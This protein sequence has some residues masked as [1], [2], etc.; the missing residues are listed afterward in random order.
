LSAAGPLPMTPERP[1]SI[2]RT[3]KGV[4]ARFA[5]IDN[6]V[7]ND[8]RLSFRARGVAAYLLSKPDNWVFS[9]RKLANSGPEGVHA[10]EGAIREMI[11]LAY[12]TRIRNRDASGKLR[13]RLVFHEAPTGT[14]RQS[15]PTGT[16]PT[17]GEPTGR[18]ADGRQT[19]GVINDGVTNDGVTNDGVTNDVPGVA[20]APPDEAPFSLSDDCPDEL[21]TAV[22]APVTASEPILG[23]PARRHH[24]ITQKWG[25][26]FRDSF[27]FDYKFDGKD[28]AALKRFLDKFPATAT[29]FLIV[30]RD[31]WHRTKRDQFASAC[32]RAGT[33]HGLCAFWNDI[34]VELTRPATSAQRGTSGDGAAA[35]SGN[36]PSTPPVQKPMR[37]LNCI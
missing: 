26:L 20:A 33:I 1:Q 22:T 5:R 25:A 16:L 17:V 10:M 28:A 13:S 6:S 34:R 2:F 9:A 21:L 31:A 19:A 8:E 23:D 37:M 18:K 30:A 32:K 3:P 27:N 14:F 29:E 12:I 35:R 4:N 24:E 7:V 11:A 36:R 15:A